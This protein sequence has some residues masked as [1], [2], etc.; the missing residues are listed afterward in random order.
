VADAT[1]AYVVWRGAYTDST[2]EEWQFGIRYMLI[3]SAGTPAT[4]GD[5]PTFGVTHVD[6]VRSETDW[7]IHS[8]WNADLG[9]TSLTV[10]D[11]LNDQLGA[12]ARDHFAELELSNHV[13][14]NSVK[15]SP[16]N[17][18]GHVVDERTATLTWTGSNPTGSSG[19]NQ[20]PTEVSVVCSW[21]TPRI[22][23]KGRGRVYLPP[24]A[25]GSL[26][27]TGRLTSASQDAILAGMTNFIQDSALGGGFDH[28]WALPVVTGAPYTSYGQIVGM[29]VGDVYDSQRRRRRQLVETRVSGA[30]SY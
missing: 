11:W 4:E 18:A 16:I 14:L 13:K 30:L 21:K 23:R 25:A 9:A 17:A 6:V 22:G 19:T 2:P 27:S 5:L 12:T 10:D 28:V 20:L 7:D 8:S 29:N 24:A 1:H 26:T 3:N 15:V